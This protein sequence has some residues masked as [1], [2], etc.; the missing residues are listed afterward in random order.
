M[1]VTDWREDRSGPVM[2]EIEQVGG[3]GFFVQADVSRREDNERMVDACI[4][5]YGK[6]DILFCN[7]GRFLPKLI[8]ESTTKR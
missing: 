6:L 5:R 1:V 2:E 8:T 3:E 4:E 7:A